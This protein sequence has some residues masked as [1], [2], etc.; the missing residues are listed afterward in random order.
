MAGDLRL[1]K[2]LAKGCSLVALALILTGTLSKD[3]IAEKPVQADTGRPALAGSSEHNPKAKGLKANGLKSNGPE[4]NGPEAS[5]TEVSRTEVSRTET[6][7]TEEIRSENQSRTEVS[8]T[9]TVRSPSPDLSLKSSDKP[10]LQ[11]IFGP[12]TIADLVDQVAPSV[13]NIVCTS[14]ISHDQAARMKLEQRGR[15]DAVRKLRKHFGLYVPTEQ[16]GNQ[17]RTTGAGVLVRSDGYILTSLH[18]VRDA[19]EMKVTLK[20]G[21]SF[22]ARVI[23]RDG[24]S[25]LAVIKIDTVGLPTAKFGDDKH[26]RL[27]QWVFAIG[28]PYAYENSVS[29]GLISGLHREAKNF[30]PAFGARTGALTFIQTDVALNPGSSGGPL[31]NFQ[32]EVIGIN[33]FVRDE[34]Q[35]IGFAIPSN[36]AKRI[37]DE[38]MSKGSA[39]HPFLGVEMRDSEEMPEG[40]GVIKGVEVTKV[41]VPS[42]ADKAGIQV[43]DLIV[44]IDSERILSPKDVSRVVAAHLIGDRM[45]VTVHRAG[46]SKKISVKVEGLPEEF[47]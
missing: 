38:L 1:I 17:I 19:E 23:G 32:G 28:N 9:E 4:A 10:L 39:P 5:R 33:S 46:S 20:D 12:D 34:A 21:R 35:N 24:F 30:T 7:R 3:A 42:P 45:N 13:V 40:A 26:L 11:K 36:M 16:V 27:G 44:E 25:D 37:A 14:L 31:I 22:D 18:V 15:E 29:A 6:A 47:D 8:R 41:K 2:K 43:G